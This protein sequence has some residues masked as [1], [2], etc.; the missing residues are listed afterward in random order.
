MCPYSSR[1]RQGSNMILDWVSSN[2]NQ[3]NREKTEEGSRDTKNNLQ[4]SILHTTPE[5]CYRTGNL[6]ENFSLYGGKGKPHATDRMSVSPPPTPP[7][8]AEA[9]TL[10]MSAFRDRTYVRG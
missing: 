6:T 7:P 1:P 8:Y 9:P 10:S 3:N 4:S 2:E 5:Q